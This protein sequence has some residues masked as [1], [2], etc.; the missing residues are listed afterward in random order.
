MRLLLAQK[1]M[2]L[3]L[4]MRAD[5]VL[6]KLMRAAPLGAGRAGF[7]ATLA[8]MRMHEGDLNG[9]I[10]ALSESNS[11][12]M[13]DAVRERRALI[14]ARVEAERGETGSAV[15]ILSGTQTLGADET[16][17]AILEQAKDWPAARD[18]LKLL[19]ARVVPASGM[20]DD[21]QLKVELR[22][23]TA[24]ARAGD[25]TTLGSLR[26]QL[27]ARIGHGPDADLFR[28]LTAAPVRSR[29]DLGR[30]RAEMGLARAITE[31]IG[32]RKP[33]AKTP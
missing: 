27:G 32:P 13:P 16:R 25:D 24:S 9:A 5:P 6:T 17:A 23:A 18:A 22:L 28:L 3:D 31:D 7:G 15:D 21:L 30:A 8:T 19:A 1:L 2:A 12:D 29:A 4:P 11:A 26:E 33:I 20:L 10:L 14:M